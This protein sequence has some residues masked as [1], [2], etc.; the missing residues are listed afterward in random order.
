MTVYRTAVLV[1]TAFLLPACVFH[2]GDESYIPPPAFLTSVD[3]GCSACV[4]AQATHPC[5]PTQVGQR[6]CTG[7]PHARVGDTMILCAVGNAGE[8]RIGQ[9]E[10]IS[11]DMQM[12]TVTPAR[13]TVTHCVNEHGNATLQAVGPGAVTVIVNERLGGAIARTVSASF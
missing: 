1:M 3:A 6:L 2:G 8:G 12:A 10:W 13:L 7:I 4:P 11:S 5:A 9:F